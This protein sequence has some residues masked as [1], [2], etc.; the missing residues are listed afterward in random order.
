MCS[1]GTVFALGYRRAIGPRQCSVSHLATL[2]ASPLLYLDGSSANLRCCLLQVEVQC[3]EGALG[4]VYS[5]LN[6]KRG[7]VFEEVCPR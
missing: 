1:D 5:V 2:S 7:M 4:G 6:Q 3:P